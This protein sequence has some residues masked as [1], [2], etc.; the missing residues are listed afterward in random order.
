MTFL[1]Q[2]IQRGN[3]FGLPLIFAKAA[4][5]SSP[6]RRTSARRIENDDP[7]L[8]L[9][10]S[11]PLTRR[12]RR[13]TERAGVSARSSVSGNSTHRAPNPPPHVPAKTIAPQHDITTTPVQA[14]LSQVGPPLPL[15]N[16]HYL[17]PALNWPSPGK[18]EHGEDPFGREE[19]GAVI[20][21]MVSRHGAAPSNRSSGTPST[22]SD[23]DAFVTVSLEPDTSEALVG[24]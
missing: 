1:D 10:Q 21:Q 4:S 23:H 14:G 13:D 3:F 8:P 20:V 9:F 22:S 15:R 5:S 12:S 19:A 24:L 6:A 2:C 17:C 18:Y 16:Q 7:H 11:Y